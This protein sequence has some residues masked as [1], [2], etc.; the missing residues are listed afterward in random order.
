[1]I[2]KV[3]P[4]PEDGPDALARLLDSARGARDRG[5]W[6]VAERRFHR[7][8]AMARRIGAHK[9]TADALFILSGMRLMEKDLRTSRRFATEAA[10]IYARLGENAL[11]MRAD[12]LAQTA[13]AMS[14]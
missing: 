8:L 10:D 13:V 2:A 14:R 4:R 7:A 1:M 11:T 12:K 5:A 6:R 3:L 9:E